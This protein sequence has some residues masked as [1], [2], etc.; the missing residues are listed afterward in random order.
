MAVMMAA[1]PAPADQPHPA[2]PPEQ[3]L[4][5]VP[6]DS[7]EP[8]PPGADFAEQLL[9]APM[10]RVAPLLCAAPCRAT[11]ASRCR[12]PTFPPAAPPRG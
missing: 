9:P 6:A 3:G 12:T 2:A 11:P 8:S 1:D 5:R 4:R 10:P 7:A